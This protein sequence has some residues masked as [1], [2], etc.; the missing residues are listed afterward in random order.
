MN[1]KTE[2]VILEDS[3]NIHTG[4]ILLLFLAKYNKLSYE[5]SDWQ[6]ITLIV[7]IFQNY[8]KNRISNLCF[9]KLGIY[10]KCF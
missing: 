8:T 1:I 7:V 5:V 3:S 10:F 6:C 2:F 9:L 4:S